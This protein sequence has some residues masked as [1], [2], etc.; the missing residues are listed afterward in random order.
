MLRD[1]YV[2][3]SI[4]LPTYQKYSPSTSYSFDRDKSADLT[5]YLMVS[6]L[7]IKSLHI[8]LN[9]SFPMNF[10]DVSILHTSL[11]VLSWM[12]C[13]NALVSVLISECTKETL[14]ILIHTYKCYLECYE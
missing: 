3:T 8:D 4:V 2:Y 12:L 11:K 1:T 6:I 14:I 13:I 10:N 9:R 7:C 5:Y